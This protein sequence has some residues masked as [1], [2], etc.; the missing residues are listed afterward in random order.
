[1][2]GSFSDWTGWNVVIALATVV[3]AV[4]TVALVAGVFVAAY[5]LRESRRAAQLSAA[6]DLLREYRRQDMRLARFALHRLPPC[7]PSRG[8]EQLSHT[9]REALELV[10]HYLD[11]I[12]SLVARRLLRP[13][14]AAS[15]LGGSAIGIWSAIAPYVRA[16]RAAGRRPTYQRHFEYFV[17][18]LQGIPFEEEIDNLGRMPVD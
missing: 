6:V 4:A 3:L 5:T 14:P 15:F 13:E 7:D 11:N 10:S 1:V 12:G 18:L 2:L 16:E 9:D 8:L 17:Y